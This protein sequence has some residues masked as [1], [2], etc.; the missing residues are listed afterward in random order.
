[1]FSAK[2]N[3]GR[4]LHISCQLEFYNLLQ[5]AGTLRRLVA[6]RMLSSFNLLITRTLKEDGWMEDWSSGICNLIW[7]SEHLRNQINFHGPIILRN[8]LQSWFNFLLDTHEK[9]ALNILMICQG[10]EATRYRPPTLKRCIRIWVK[11]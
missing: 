8:F 6:L 7:V 11:K 3:L 10:M 5:F 1:M 9:R 2:I 4:F